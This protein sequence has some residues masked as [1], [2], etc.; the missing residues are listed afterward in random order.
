MSHLSESSP[1]LLLR[2][3]RIAGQVGAVERAILSE[4][5]CSEIL[6]LVAAVRG[7]VNG[8]L[9]EIIADHLQEHVA[10]ADLSDDERAKG[11]E[12]LLAVIRRY[13]K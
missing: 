4:G 7:A 3:R 6:H 2:V 1:D 11:A 5:S 9:N 13:A 8:L 12:E 10:H